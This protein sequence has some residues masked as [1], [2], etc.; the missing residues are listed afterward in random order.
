M[1]SSSAPDGVGEQ[2]RKPLVA[3]VAAEGEAASLLLDGHGTIRDCNPAAEALFNCRCQELAGQPVSVLLPQLAG[4]DLLREGRPNPRLR[5]LCR[6]GHHFRAQTKDGEAFVAEIFL[7]LLD[8]R[9][10]GSLSLLVRP[11]SDAPRTGADRP[12]PVHHLG[13]RF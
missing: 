3:P 11:A 10:A 13:S 2:Q 7:N 6:V 8:G 9:N 5:F 4:M 1:A 12:P